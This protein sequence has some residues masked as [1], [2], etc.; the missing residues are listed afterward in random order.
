MFGIFGD[1]NKRELKKLEPLVQQVNEFEVGVEK[2]SK[3]DIQK[4]T[5]EL[6]GLVQQK[7]QEALKTDQSSPD[8]QM[9]ADRLDQWER[10]RRK[11]AIQK[12]TEEVLPE[13]FALVREAARRTLKERHFDVQLYGGMVL[14]QGKIAEMRTGEGKTLVATLPV[15]LNALAG[16]GVHVV[17]VNDYLA[18]RDAAWMGQVYDYL[19]LTVAAIGHEASLL[20]DPKRKAELEK[21]AQKESEEQGLVFTSD[22]SPLAP[23]TRSAAYAADITY[24]T[25][26]E[27]G[28]DY[29]RDNMAQDAS[30]AVQRGLHYAIVD[31]V[32]SIL[33]DEARTP[34]IISAPAAESTSEYRRFAGLVRN[35]EI[36]TDYTVDEKLKAVVLTDDGIKKMESLLGIANI[37]D[38]GGVILVHHLEEALKA[39]VLFSRDRD[40]VV[41]DGEVVIV[42]EFTGR[43][44]PGRRYS[45][46][47]H[48]AIEAK[49][50][51]EVK[52][53]SMTLATIS[54]QN[55]FRLYDKLAGMTGTAAT[56]AEEF[57][58]IYHL[59]VVEIPTNRPNQRTD[60]PDLVYKTAGAKFKAVVDEITERNKQGQPIL[61]GTVSIE[62]NELLSDLLKKSGV[63]HELLNAKN[64]EREAHVIAGAGHKGAVTVATN[65]AGRGTDIKLGPGAS[66]LGG[67]HVIG[68]ERHESRRIDNQLRGRTGR[69]GDAGSSQFFISMEDDLMRIFGGD[70]LKNIMTT[71][72]MPEDQPIEHGMISRAIEGAQKK[73]EGHNFDIRKHLVEYDDV[74]NKHREV[75]YRRRRSVLL[76][77]EDGE[78]LKSEIMQLLEHRIRAVLEVHLASGA[79]LDTARTELER[80][81]GVSLAGIDTNLETIKGKVEQIYQEREKTLG[82]ELTRVVERSVYLRAIDVLWIEHL[83]NMDRLREGIS[84]RGYGQYDP[85]VAYKQESYRMFQDLLAAIESTVVETIFRVEVAQQNQSAKELESGASEEASGQ[86]FQEVK[87]EQKVAK[88]L[89]K[90]DK[91]QELMQ[92][93]TMRSSVPASSKKP[94]RNDPCWCGSGKKYKKCHG[95]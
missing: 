53:E 34:L 57:H 27:F 18:K 5:G 13:A 88:Q 68:T 75:I 15:Y 9:T 55:L 16:R 12:A 17:T 80:M 64:H 56:E 37:Y 4:R 32:D 79:E 73:V 22:D 50:G 61:V 51:V 63:K 26:N 23:I 76:Q 31:E 86:V 85:L 40:Y 87:T 36:E 78:G 25:N 33:I 67:L 90:K 30:Q 82:D 95:K 91:V 89:A 14:H 6:K 71:L 35:L 11:K 81:L 48:Q 29:L 39:E 84:L 10:T 45:E 46:G 21:A 41:K 7:L 77:R 43:L 70:R 28:F 92:R 59:D 74:M 2:L 38:S 94:G 60:F 3:A 83:T 93:E 19:G 66:E 69:Q 8:E 42:D 20:Y 1:L 49:E 52:K 72:K 24:G 47:L 65:L 62:K 58:K 54:F 44:M